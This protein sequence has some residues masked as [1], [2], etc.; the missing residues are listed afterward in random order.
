MLDNAVVAKQNLREHQLAVAKAQVEDFEAQVAA[1]QG[2]GRE[3]GQSIDWNQELHWPQPPPPTLRPFYEDHAV[4]QRQNFR[5]SL[6]HRITGKAIKLERALDENI[7][8]GREEDG[9]AFDQALE[10]H[11]RAIQGINARRAL[12]KEV[13]AG[14]V[15]VYTEVVQE[16]GPFQELSDLGTNVSMSFRGPWKC[17]IELEVKG[18]DVAP[19]TIRSLTST[20][21]L[22]EKNMPTGRKNEIYQDYVCGCLFRLARETHAL[23]PVKFVL[24]SAFSSM[25]D[26]STGRL[27]RQCICSAGFPTSEF[28]QIDF[29]HVDFSDALGLFRHHMKFSKSAGF[30]PVT[31]LN[32]EDFDLKWVG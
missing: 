1:L 15:S 10:A 21:K 18:P 24:C 28:D 11:G 2:I 12:A 17:S 6:I 23:L 26:T 29:R 27:A 16:L 30:S 32:L 31:P 5:P 4:R 8:R 25:L 7:Q 19:S 20:G 9:K 22:S 3:C 14:N 13:L